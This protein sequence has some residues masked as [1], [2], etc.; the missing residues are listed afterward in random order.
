MFYGVNSPLNS[1]RQIN[2]VISAVEDFFF[3]SDFFLSKI[4]MRASRPRESKLCIV[5]NTDLG[6][7]V[8][9]AGETMLKNKPHL[10]KFNDCIM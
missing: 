5:C 7:T 2:E 6:R 3:S 8:Q 9:T 10:V 1:I 4:R